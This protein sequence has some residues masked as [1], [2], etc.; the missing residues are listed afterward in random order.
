MSR[1]SAT[2]RGAACRDVTLARPHVQGRRDRS[3]R[4]ARIAHLAARFRR[5]IRPAKST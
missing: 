5:R 3:P 4:I 2:G 1:A